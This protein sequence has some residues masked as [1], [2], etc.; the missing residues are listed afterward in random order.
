MNER[1][2][3]ISKLKKSAQFRASY[4]RA[5]LNISIPSQIRALRRR[6]EL[7]QTALALEAGMKQSRISA[8]ERP[9]ETKF[10]LETLIRLAATFKVGLVV[11]FAPF[12]ELLD[13][14]NRFSQD[15]FNVAPI[16]DDLEFLR[17]SIAAEHVKDRVALN[18]GPIERR[19][20]ISYDATQAPLERLRGAIEDNHVIPLGQSSTP[21]GRNI[22]QSFE[23]PTFHNASLKEAQFVR[24]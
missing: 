18:A 3:T 10:N 15:H 19:A 11:K 7:T 4:L 14:E 16:D 23:T 22:C 9:G 8:M 20:P 13:W 5:K 6:H 1:S 17:P 2:D 12:S 21:A 24:R